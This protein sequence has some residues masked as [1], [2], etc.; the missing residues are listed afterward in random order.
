MPEVYVSS[1]NHV[2]DPVI[3]KYRPR[4]RN[5]R[6]HDN[7]TWGLLDQVK[8]EDIGIFLGDSFL[9]PDSVERLKKYKFQKVLIIGNHEFDHGVTLPMLMEAFDEVHASFRLGR[10]WLTHIPMHPETLGGRY[11]I[12]GHIHNRSKLDRDTRYINVS[13][14]A[15]GY[16]LITL[17]E[18]DNDTY[19]P[20]SK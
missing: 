11:N 13:M 7:A 16:R 10:Y 14:E 8:D 2:G 6:E 17:N 12:H 15:T 1:D 19:Q 5:I 3:L 18:I 9:T 4:F 20:W